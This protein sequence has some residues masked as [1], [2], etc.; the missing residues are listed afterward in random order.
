MKFEKLCPSCN[1]PWDKNLNCVP[2]NLHRSTSPFP[3]PN[4]Y[5][6][7]RAWSL[8]IYIYWNADETCQYQNG[9]KYVTLPWLSFDI[10][11]EQIQLYLTFS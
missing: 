4:E 1:N 6:V 9:D 5:W 10:T 2:C 8:F 3:G 7:F 11:H